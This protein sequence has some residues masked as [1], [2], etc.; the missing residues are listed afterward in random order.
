MDVNVV[1]E[2]PGVRIAR[3]KVMSRRLPRKQRVTA[4]EA[5]AF[6]QEAYKVEV[7]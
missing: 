4:D 1:L 5:I 2:R 7:E 6:L 3:R